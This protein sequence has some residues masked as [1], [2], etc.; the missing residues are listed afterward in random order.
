MPS[1]LRAT[2][3]LNRAVAVRAPWPGGE[4]PTAPLVAY[5]CRP[6]ERPYL[7]PVHGPGAGPVLTQ[8][9]PSDHPWQHGIFTGLHQ[10][11]GLDFW[12]EH[13]FPEKS[14]VVRLER[15]ADLSGDDQAVGWT[16]TSRWL[17]RAEEPVLR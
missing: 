16:A 12:Q 4:E 17:T 7:H 9:R 11:N 8:D 13:R 10:V 15:L 3:E 2:Y 1:G 14:G 6:G 5:R